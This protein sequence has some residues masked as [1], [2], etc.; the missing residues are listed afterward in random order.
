[1]GSLHYG[2]ASMDGDPADRHCKCDAIHLREVFATDELWAEL[3]VRPQRIIRQACAR[4]TSTGGAI[5]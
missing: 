4:L 1:M 2:P 5:D 3:A